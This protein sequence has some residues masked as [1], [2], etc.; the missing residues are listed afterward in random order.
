MLAA[1]VGDC[2]DF[3]LATRLHEVQSF[4][5]NVLEPLPLP[6]EPTLEGAGRSKKCVS[7]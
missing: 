5:A 1:L 7:A 3:F 4:L 2:G 6:A